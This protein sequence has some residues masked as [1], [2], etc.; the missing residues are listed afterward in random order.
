M[1]QSP[2]FIGRT[3]LLVVATTLSLG[4]YSA[5]AQSQET[6]G[7]APA[8]SLELNG[9]Q[10]SEKGCR[11]T[12]VVANDLGA[13]LTRAAFEIALFNDAGVVDRL[14]VLDFRDLPA[15]K[16]KVSRFDLAG[17]DCAK[18]SRVLVN[19]V[20]ECSG[21]D[22]APDACMKSLKTSSRAGIVFGL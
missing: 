19:S 16:T 13:D 5:A 11:L 14:T 20:T 8:L 3:H 12:F 6:S 7:S 21:K 18:M 4:L 2:S 9:I 1:K 10:P 17:A 22:I 15:G